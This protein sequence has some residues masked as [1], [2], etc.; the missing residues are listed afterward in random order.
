MEFF[1]CDIGD[2]GNPDGVVDQECFN[3]Y[4]LTRAPNAKDA[5]AIDPNFPG[6]YYVDPPCRADDEV[7]QNVTDNFP[8]GAYNVKMRYTLPDIE[9]E[10]CV[11]QMHYR[12][13]PKC[14][15]L[16][17]ALKLPLALFTRVR[18]LDAGRFLVDGNALRSFNRLTLLRQHNPCGRLHAHIIFSTHGD[19]IYYRFSVGFSEPLVLP[20]NSRPQ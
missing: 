18:A 19:C 14:L 6:R 11:L 15:F 7:D 1:L 20:P 16:S 5:S 13:S 8:E 9:C 12:E 2:L 4:P 17:S 10:H 3:Q